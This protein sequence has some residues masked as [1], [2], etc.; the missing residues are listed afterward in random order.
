[1]HDCIQGCRIEVLIF[2]MDLKDQI[3]LRAVNRN[4][5]ETGLGMV[6][7]DEVRHRTCSRDEARKPA[8]I[9]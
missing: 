1:M 3:K 9:F 6:R 8:S 5:R 7:R 4:R 2:E